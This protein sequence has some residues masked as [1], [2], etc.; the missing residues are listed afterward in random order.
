M[1]KITY[2]LLFIST[3]AYAQKPVITPVL[4]GLV[5]LLGKPANTGMTKI[6]LLFND[7]NINVIKVEK[8]DIYDLLPS[9]EKKIILKRISYSLSPDSSWIIFTINENEILEGFEFYSGTIYDDIK[10]ISGIS[11]L[12]EINKYGSTK[13]YVLR[14]YFI[15]DDGDYSIVAFHN[16]K[17]NRV[18]TAKLFPISQS[19]TRKNAESAVIKFLHDC[20]IKYL[21]KKT[22]SITD[23]D[24][25]ITSYMSVL[26]FSNGISSYIQH[27]GEIQINTNSPATQIAI[28]SHLPKDMKEIWNN[29]DEKMYRY[30]KDN[31]LVTITEN[32]F[33]FK[34]FP[35]AREFL[36]DKVFYTANDKGVSF[37]SL[38]K[39]SISANKK[40]VIITWTKWCWPC[41]NTVDNFI[42]HE[43]I[44][45]LLLNRDIITNSPS[46]T[47]SV[48]KI[49]EWT[50][51]NGRLIYH[52]RIL[53]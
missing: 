47:S 14:N 48:E 33:N 41:I 27:D 11:N 44:N 53:L 9:G 18:D 45:L 42:N 35:D 40:T 38:L 29:V 32:D 2:L 23:G 21:A 17:Q 16:E 25:L 22:E 50:K 34:Y 15:K 28:R 20:G 24:D 36:R 1:Q 39:N 4:T 31:A 6:D 52:L 19:N 5:S 26:Y 51:K 13:N 43:D 37:E 3:F 49:L 7:N 30:K 10:R 46:I 8:H 12:T